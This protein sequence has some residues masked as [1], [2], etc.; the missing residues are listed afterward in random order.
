MNLTFSFL[1]L[2]EVEAV[3]QVDVID[4]K[5]ISNLLG[6]FSTF[7]GLLTVVL[8][9]RYTTHSM[10]SYKFHLINMTVNI[11]LCDLSIA[12]FSIPHTIFPANGG[13]FCCCCLFGKI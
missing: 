12:V 6:A 7:F 3:S 1:Q 4:Y 8:I 10:L 9:S 11:L 5:W 13:F 2:N